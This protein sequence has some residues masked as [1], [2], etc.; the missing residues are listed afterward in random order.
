MRA[1]PSL[2][3]LQQ[4]LDP[5]EFIQGATR[6]RSG[7]VL[8]MAL[9]AAELLSP[10]FGILGGGG[11]VAFIAGGLLL[12]DRDVPGFGVPVMLVVLLAGTSLA[13]V[14]LGGGMALRARRRPVLGGAEEM[15]GAVGVVSE[16][17]N[18]EAW[19]MVHGERWHVHS[20]RPLQPG[21]AVRVCAMHGLLLEVEPTAPAPP[22]PRGDTR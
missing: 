6:E 15:P 21:Q 10:G 22:L 8:G 7:L 20:A 11:I 18:G 19:A 2:N 4:P 17:H 16:V 12:F 3:V 9:M 14:L 13:A 5:G 1:S